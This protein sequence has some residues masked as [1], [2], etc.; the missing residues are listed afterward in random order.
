MYTDIE[1][2]LGYTTA[3][4]P[5]WAISGSEDDDDDGTGLDTSSGDVDDSD[6]SDESEEDEWTPPSREDWEKVQAALKKAQAEA[7]RRRLANKAKEGADI[8]EGAEAVEKAVA[9]AEGKWK[10]KVIRAEARG[11]LASAGVDS[12]KLNKAL[13]LLDMDEIDVDEDDEVHGLEDQ[14]DELRE[15]FPE[16][17]APKHDAASHGR[18]VPR[19]NGAGKTAPPK[20]KSSADLLGAL[21]GGRK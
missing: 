8:P 13:R 10:T 18:R 17:F 21:L 7:K 11:A 2:I 20:P 9:E 3:G 15:E 14:I 5:I 6:D 12:A 4:L 19:A 16:L 1:K